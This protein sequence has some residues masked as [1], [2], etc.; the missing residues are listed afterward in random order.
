MENEKVYTISDSMCL[1]ESLTKPQIEDVVDEQV[2][3]YGVPVNSVMGF[4][5]TE[6]E[7]PAGF[8]LSD[9]PIGSGGGGGE[10]DKVGVVKMFS[11]STAP[12][13][14]LICD[15]SAVSRTTYSELF[16]II[17]TTYGVGDN[18]TTFNIPNIKGRT[19]VGLNS[20]D[21]DFNVL[22]KNGGEKTHTL[23]INEIPAH[24]HNLTYDKS[25]AGANTGGTVALGNTSTT[26]SLA[27]LPTGGGQPHNNLQP[28][29]VLNYIIKASTTTPVQAEVIDSLDGDSTTNA[30]SV[31][32]VNEGLG[33]IRGRILWTNPNPTSGFSDQT[34]NFNSSDFDVYEVFYYVSVEN[35][36][37]ESCKSLKGHGTRLMIP[38]T[39]MDFRRMNAI[40][41]TSYF[42]E[43]PSNINFG[44]PVKI[45]GYK[46][47]LFD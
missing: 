44:V 8:E 36:Q 29:I 40:S 20:S 10:S 11:G 30:P 42:F 3:G 19:V 4:T 38:S 25:G 35:L 14:W 23:T 9:E 37:L 32:A 34:I 1:E 33:N 45:I 22:G 12:E 18:S 46:I 31:R 2:K 41:D 24:T 26:S 13:G 6:T 28:Y 47:G 15:G 21:T 27:T 17:G 16:S 39:N 7:I 43:T 5:G